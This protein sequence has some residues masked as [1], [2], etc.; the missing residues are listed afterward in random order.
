VKDSLSNQNQKYLKFLD[1]FRELRKFLRKN[2]I[3]KSRE[4]NVSIYV[5]DKLY[6]RTLEII[7]IFFN[8]ITNLIELAK[9]N[10]SKS[11]IFMYL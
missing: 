11:S 2:I 10:L 5:L 9:I 3:L 7:L 4:N 6:I 1:Q 8:S